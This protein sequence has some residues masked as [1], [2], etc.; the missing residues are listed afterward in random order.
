VKVLTLSTLFPDTSRPRFGP[1]VEAQTL[2]LAARDDVDVRVVAPIGIPPMPL[3]LHPRYGALRTLPHRETWQG[4]EVYRPRFTHIPGVGGRFDAGLMAR[5]LL[6]LLTT[7]RQDFAFDV[8]DASFFF[9]DGPAAVALGEALGIPVS[10]KARGSD[11]HVWG[12]QPAVSAQILNAA[13]KAQG[14]LAVS[15]ALKRDMVAMG[16]PSDKI[17][18]HY[19]GVALDRFTPIDRAQAKASL[20]VSGPLIVCVGNLLERKG[21][22][23]VVD[24]LSEI[25]GATLALIGQ[26]SD[27]ASLE[28]KVSALGL[29]DRVRFVG[30]IAHD[31]MVIWLGAAD[32]M[33]LASVSEGL[34]NVWV[35]A[36]ACGTP[37]VI[38]DVGG[39]REVVDRPEAGRLV[40]AYPAMIAR[41]V[42][43]IIASPPPQA[44]VRVAAERF[45]WSANSEAL[46]DHLNGL[47][48][49]Y[50]PR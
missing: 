42:N 9:P 45:T 50:P 43:Q 37:I 44:L 33:V 19:T 27:R 30:S 26:G 32:V 36:L 5:A 41:A 47:I 3:G 23:L 22:R 46:F 12:A 20:S 31:E 14:L 8:I 38:T 40:A 16:M 24:A 34:A 35:E 10:I 1:F 15:Q 49:H 6:P 29:S 25:E 48:A 7:I 17:R 21:Q 13:H 39:A 18:V 28:A 4:V 11:I 2:A